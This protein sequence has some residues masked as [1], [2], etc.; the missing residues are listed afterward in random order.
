MSIASD[1]IKGGAA[2]ILGGIGEAAKGIRAAIKGPEVSAEVRGQIELQ[3]VAIEAQALE[4]DKA[5]GLAQI[6]LAKAD[7]QSG[8]AFQRRWRPAIGWTCAFALAYQFLVRPLAPWALTVAGVSVPEMPPLV[9]GEL[10]PLMLGMLG[11]GGM[12]SYE[13]VRGSAK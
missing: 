9:M 11:L 13:K 6:D 2:G 7:A 5:V 8:D 12:R 3:V 10:W 1:L 4:M